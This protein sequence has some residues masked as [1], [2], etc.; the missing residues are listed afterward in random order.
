M[1]KTKKVTLL[2]DPIYGFIGIRSPLIFEIISHPWF[3][4]LRRISQ[5]GFSCYVYPGAHHT[6]FEHALGAM[7]LMQE[8]IEVLRKKGVE[9]SGEEAE[10]MQ[11]AILLHD[12]GHGP[13]SHTTEALLAGKVMHEE[14]SLEVMKKLNDEFKGALDLP[15]AIFTNQYKRKFMHQLIVGQIDLDRMDYLKRDS[16]YS[17]ATEGNINSKRIIEMMVV[18]DDQLAFEEK[19]I[20]SIEKFLMARRLMYWQVYLHKTSLSAEF[21]LSR[22]LERVRFCNQNGVQPLASEPLAYFLSRNDVNTHP[23]DIQLE[24]F[25]LLDDS[26]IIQGLKSWE[27]DAD[28]VLSKL[29]NMLLNRR[30]LKIKVQDQPFEPEAVARKH[31]R[32]KNFGFAEEDYPYFV[33]TGAVSNQTY[34]PQDKQIWILSKNGKMK[35]LSE[36]DAFFDSEELSRIQQKYFLCFPRNR[37]LT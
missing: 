3:Q 36:A 24:N 32:L 8:V 25:L 2:N 9:I 22:I 17:G 13:F 35:E 23:T 28:K 16:F 5:M 31:Q 37:H 27:N 10:A 18:V 19:S 21:L 7:H 11:L 33:F 29:S 14:I 1:L 34:V 12:I 15:I 6:R 20:Y 26:D 4:R 30:L